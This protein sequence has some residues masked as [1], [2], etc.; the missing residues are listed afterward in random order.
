MPKEHQKGKRCL[1]NRSC[2]RKE[3]TE[4]GDE[5]KVD[6]WTDTQTHTHIH[7]QRSL[8]SW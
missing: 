7:R 4:V 3:K 2:R 1:R 8:S 5:V 6:L